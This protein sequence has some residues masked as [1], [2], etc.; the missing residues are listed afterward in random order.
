MRG[1][2][3]KLQLTHR[4]YWR[5]Y[6]RV[7]LSN[8]LQLAS[9]LSILILAGLLGIL[10]LKP[11]QTEDFNPAK[12]LPQSLHREIVAAEQGIFSD[13]MAYKHL[14]QL[15]AEVNHYMTDIE[16]WQPGNALEQEIKKQEEITLQE[17]QSLITTR[18]C[19]EQ[20]LKLQVP[21]TLHTKNILT[22]NQQGAWKNFSTAEK[23]KLSNMIK[24]VDLLAT[25]V[26]V[27]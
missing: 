5:Y 22:I 20:Q 10:L 17:F 14:D 9:F 11:V 21:D 24:R 26:G 27:R 8:L 19:M 2:S 12:G 1:L 4:T 15:K 3:Y 16:T 18:S 25:S 7:K 23:I 13:L 6:R